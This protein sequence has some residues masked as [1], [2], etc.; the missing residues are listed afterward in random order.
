MLK[1]AIVFMYQLLTIASEWFHLTDHASVSCPVKHT[2]W[3][4]LTKIITLNANAKE[5]ITLNMYP[6]PPNLTKIIT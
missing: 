4:N 5:I 1:E 3:P 2:L 6:T